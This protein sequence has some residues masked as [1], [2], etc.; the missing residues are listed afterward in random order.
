MSQPAAFE[1]V[2]LQ[3][4]QARVQDSVTYIRKGLDEIITR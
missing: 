4:R 3:A 2:N 1:A